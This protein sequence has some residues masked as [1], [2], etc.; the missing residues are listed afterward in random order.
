MSKTPR[1]L[2]GRTPRM[3]KVGMLTIEFSDVKD[4]TMSY[5]ACDVDKL[6]YFT[7]KKKAQ[8]PLTINETLYFPINNPRANIHFFLYRQK[9]MGSKCV[10][11]Y[12]MNLEKLKPEDAEMHYIQSI[13]KPKNIVEP[14]IGEIRTDVE[15]ENTDKKKKKKKNEKKMGQFK[16][17]MKFTPVPV[18]E[19]KLEGIV[20]DGE[21]KEK[22]DAGNIIGNPKW[23][24]NPQFLLTLSSKLH[25]K[26]G[27]KQNDKTN[28]VTYFIIKYDL[29]FY[30]DS[31]LKIFDPNEVIKIDE[32]FLNTMAS[33][34]IEQTFQLDAGSYVII[35][36]NLSRALGDEKPYHGKFQIAVHS[37]H[38][39]GIEFS[40][41]D[42][43]KEWNLFKD[44]KTWDEN[45][46][47]GSDRGSPYEF[48]HN[49]QYYVNATKDTKVSI[50]LEQPDNNNKIGFYLFDCKQH[51]RKEI[52]F[53]TVI[54]ESKCLISTVCV[55]KNFN[56]LKGE[57]ILVPCCSEEKVK[58]EFTMRVF[59]KEKLEI[60]ELK[61]PWKNMVSIDG[62]WQEGTAGGSINDKELFVTNPQ[63][64]IKAKYNGESCKDI[65]IILSQFIG[66]S[67][68][69]ESIGLP[70]FVNL[71]QRYG[72]EDIDED[73]LVNLPDAWV[74]NRN[75]FCCFEVDEED[76]LELTVI[77]STMKPNCFADFKIMVLSDLEEVTIEELGEAEEE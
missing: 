77:P 34:M 44:S 62:K 9:L 18:E 17:S 76:G 46:N 52:D 8:K 22:F 2:Q 50:S 37:E 71:E 66:S 10:G 16:V 68:N 15:D 48:Y 4:K 55:G 35:P 5:I 29:A 36:T 49:Y 51:E 64:V 19:K 69:I 14:D 74:K 40:P 41:I 24:E 45:T 21:W 6:S 57:Y 1:Q 70:A 53:E 30:E 59:S 72:A 3:G 67:G 73:N 32:N 60:E 12:Q 58:G 20:L 63:Y 11:F 7:T 47:G 75:V 56:L 43:K 28:R 27:L 38:M 42:V 65:N 26:I 33:D 23:Y 61:N 25:V 39:E 13:K 54:N 31:P